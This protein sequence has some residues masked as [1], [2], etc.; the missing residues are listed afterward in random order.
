MLFHYS[1]VP[2]LV[3]VLS[4]PGNITYGLVVGRDALCVAVTVKF[5][6]HGEIFPV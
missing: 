5:V 4:I 3:T 6:S 2:V 1:V